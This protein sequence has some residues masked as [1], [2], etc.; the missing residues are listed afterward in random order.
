M[1]WSCRKFKTTFLVCFSQ[2]SVE[3]RRVTML[4]TISQSVRL[5]LEPIS[6]S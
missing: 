3:L 4:L 5:G 1:N 6:D 2:R